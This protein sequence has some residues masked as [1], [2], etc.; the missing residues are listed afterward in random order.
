[1]KKKIYIL[2]AAFNEAGA[3]DQVIKE[4]KTAG[5]KNIILIDDGSSDDTLRIA[6]K[7]RVQIIHHLINRG[8]GAAVKTGIEIAKKL[9]AQI[10][11]TMDGD[12]QHNPKNIKEMI[13]KIDQGFDVVLGSRMIDSKGMPKSRVAANH[14]GNFFTW[15]LYGIWVSDSQSGFRAYNKKAFFL[16]DTKSDHYE[17]DSE[18]ISEISRNNLKTVEVPIETRY[19]KY[20]LGKKNK[21]SLLN[22]VSMFFRMILTS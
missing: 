19:T 9:N 2:I 11:V 13:K 3:I 12:G 5:Y 1:M 4:V 20:S 10:I 15:L 8:K 6:K 21:Q 16:I 14:L 7:N 18:V 17:F 22:G